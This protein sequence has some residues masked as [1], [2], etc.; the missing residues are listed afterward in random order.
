MLI[1]SLLLRHSRS[2]IEFDLGGIRHEFSP[3]ARLHNK[4]HSA[5]TKPVINWRSPIAAPTKIAMNVTGAL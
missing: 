5:G 2:A 4:S 3:L 1:E